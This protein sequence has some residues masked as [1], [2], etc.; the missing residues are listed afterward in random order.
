M[1]VW[2]ERSVPEIMDIVRTADT[3]L[4]D[5][6]LRQVWVNDNF[7]NRNPFVVLG[8]LAIG[9]PNLRLGTAI[10]HPFARNPVDMADSFATLTELVNGEEV[11]MGIAAGARVYNS[12][13]VD[14]LTP[15][16]SVEVVR[17]TVQI[18]SKLLSNE[19]IQFDEYP[20]VQSYYH[21]KKGGS[22][23]LWFQP[24]APVKAYGAM[25]HRH[26]GGS[27]RRVIGQFCEGV[28]MDNIRNADETRLK[29]ELDEFARLRGARP[30]RKIFKLN[31]SISDNPEEAKR[32]AKR[33]ASHAATRESQLR[34]AGI[35][36]EKVMKLIE[37]FKTHTPEVHDLTPDEMVEKFF[38]AGTPAQ[39]R[40]KIAQLFAVAQK[41][42][43]DQILI[44]VPVGPDQKKA[45]KLWATEILPSL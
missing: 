40:D 9:F 15:L 35:P 44:A 8:A 1:H 32:F 10:V 2:R 13:I 3:L 45:I 17:E 39:W 19:R 21:L 26:T 23:Q 22:A 43:F 18:V 5:F 25:R 30:F 37:G 34:A 28:I 33:I 12:E 41:Y 16:E 31:S 29:D 4:T 38:I 42:A 27:L 20:F 14:M 7:E 36:R 6:G 24:K 11:S